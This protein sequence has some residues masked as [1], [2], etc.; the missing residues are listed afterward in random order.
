MTTSQGSGLGEQIETT[1]F[2][3]REFLTWLWFESE[4]FEQKFA[5]EGFGDCTLFLE[6]K[7]ALENSAGEREKEKSALSGLA[8]SGT[9]EA[10]EALRQGKQPTQAKLVIERDDQSFA[11][12]LDAEGLAISGVKIPALVKGEGEDPFY[13]RIGLIEEIEAAIES[14]YKDFLQ[15]RLARG[16][17]REV[18][19]AIR[20]WMNDE[21]GAAIDAYRRTR[22]RAAAPKK[23]KKTPRRQLP[24]H[25]M[26]VSSSDD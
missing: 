8:P 13:E 19:P 9:P 7:L 24:E 1:R 21:H 2:V 5:I 23:P 15:L 6:K 4:V 22:A 25:A 11:L 17:Y 12:T 14:L 3:G 16:W 10:R 20:E 18:V 26:V